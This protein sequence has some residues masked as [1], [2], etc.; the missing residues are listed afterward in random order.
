MCHKHID[1][2]HCITAS[3][4]GSYLLTSTS[5]A[6]LHPFLLTDTQVMFKGREQR[7]AKVSLTPATASK[8]RHLQS[9]VASM[10][11]STTPKRGPSPQKGTPSGRDRKLSPAEMRAI[12]INSKPSPM[13]L[14]DTRGRSSSYSS[15][16]NSSLESEAPDDLPPTHPPP[17]ATLPKPPV[18]KSFSEILQQ[19]IS[20]NT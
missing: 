12:T 13:P 7:P 15:I 17:P 2:P 11:R 9:T 19:P 8:V 3:L 14:T 4:A 10:G 18:I 20:C 5:S 16:S 6:I 1:T